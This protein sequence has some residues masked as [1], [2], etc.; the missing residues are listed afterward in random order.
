MDKNTAE[1]QYQKAL[2][3]HRAGKFRDAELIYRKLAKAFPEL[4]SVWLNLGVTLYQQGRVEA[5]LKA[6]DRAIKVNPTNM[7]AYSNRAASLM[8]LNRLD[9]AVEAY[10]FLVQSD[11]GNAA[12]HYNYGNALYRAGRLV[13][14]EAAFR[15]AISSNRNLAEAHYNLGFLLKELGRL[16]ESESSFRAALVANPSYG[17]A[18]VNL[19]NILMDK[20]QPKEAI[21]NFNLSLEMDAEYDLARKALAKA[22]LAVG[23]PQKALVELERVLAKKED[24]VDAWVLKGN[25]LNDLKDTNGAREAYQQALKIEPE[26]EF[27]LKNMDKSMGKVIPGWH[28]TMLADTVRNAAYKRAIER[29][30]EKG[31]R[32]L[33]IGAGSGLLSMMAARAGAGKVDACELV[34]ELAKVA[35]EIV[36]ANGYAETIEIHELHSS[37]LEME[38]RADV[39][40]SEILDAGLIGE[41]V[42]PSHRHAVANLLKPGGKV[43]PQSAKV[44]AQLVSLPW[45]RKVSPIGEVDGFD[46]SK[47][48]RFQGMDQYQ[49]L[50]LD[51][52]EWEPLTDVGELWEV[53]LA[54]VGPATSEEYP[55]TLELS[56]KGTADGVAHAVIF[57]FDLR[58]DEREMV[59][60]APGGELKHWGQ[61]VYYFPK[62]HEVKVGQ[63]IA[64]GAL[65]TDVSWQFE[66]LA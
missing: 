33:D 30:V 19:G 15:K 25:A 51:T 47:M 54:N 16:E 38:E 34:P 5:G 62:D 6:L 2:R 55:E 37:Q 61:A 36:A 9:E 45:R 41:G 32:V 53:D 21:E 65:R 10:K 58:L 46:L 28:F 8:A 59:S 12:A 22:L 66:W 43:I 39:L 64:I 50:F 44:Y 56:L 7:D 40:V 63:E 27:A 14:A 17:M 11:P 1:R 35:R 48:R 42:L 52:E 18:Y 26:N 24:D 20:G 4:D 29:A 49:A 3:L 23:K 57:W 60:S 13:E 31:N